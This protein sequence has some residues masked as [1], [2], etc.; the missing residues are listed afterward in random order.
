MIVVIQCAAG[1]QHNAGRLRTFDELCVMFVANPDCAP[2]GSIQVYA[3]PDDNSDWG[4]SWR[5]VLQEYNDAPDN[6][7][8]GLL[9]A[10]RLYKDA[11]Y[12]MLMEHCGPERLYILSAGWGLVRSDYLTPDYDITFSKHQNVEIFKRRRDHDE[13]N[14]FSMLPP[15]TTE[16]IT[17]FGGKAYVKL[18]CML[19]SKSRGPRYVWHNS[20]DKPDAPG[21]IVKRFNSAN[22]RRW[23]YECAQAFVQGSLEFGSG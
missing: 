10:G 7:P 6:N 23:Y 13:Y 21:C 4:Q 2:S 12:R 18:F 9:Q 8:F 20:Q 1:K 5:T 14:D 19:T 11:T 22:R 3:R 15:D 16:S 17:F